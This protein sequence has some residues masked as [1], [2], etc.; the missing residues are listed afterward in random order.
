M[1]DV[2]GTEDPDAVAAMIDAFC[3]RHLGARVARYVFFAGGVGTVHGLELA[4]ARR[5]VIKAH[6]AG[7]ARD[8]LMAVQTVQSAVA[9]GGLPAPR[10]LLVPTVIGLGIA[11]VE[12]RLLGGSATSA[13]GRAQRER[14]AA[15][16]HRFVV[17]AKPHSDA[18]GAHAGFLTGNGDELFPPAHD[19]RFDFSLP[20]GEWIDAIAADA[21]DRLTA[22]PGG[23]IVGHSDWRVENLRYQRGTL[24]A[25]YDWD[26]SVVRSEA[27]LVGAVSTLFTADW[28]Q[29]ETCGIPELCEMGAFVTA[30]EAARRRPFSRAERDLCAAACSYQLAYNARCEWSD[31]LTDMGR[32]PAAHRPPSPWSGGSIARLRQQIDGSSAGAT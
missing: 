27:A 26:S 15:D 8:Y 21:R 32:R 29:P 12:E 5:V 18:F 30:Y 31:L 2:F 9:D 17:L 22:W 23:A 3:A 19:R 16:L 20:G 25:I 28:T 10:P 4:D 6:R 11:S 14:M 24:S 7:V 1:V 13:H